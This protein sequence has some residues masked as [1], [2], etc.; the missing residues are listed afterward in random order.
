MPRPLG[1]R[2][3]TSGLWPR[4]QAILGTSGRPRVKLAIAVQG[5]QRIDPPL[6]TLAR[7][8]HSVFHHPG[9][10]PGHAS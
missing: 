9:W 4:P 7:T 8:P 3:A 6:P 1:Q 5:H 2:T 10:P